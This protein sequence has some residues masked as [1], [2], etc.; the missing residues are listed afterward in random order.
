M[1][2]WETKPLDLRRY[3]EEFGKQYRRYCGAV[4]EG[5]GRKIHQLENLLLRSHSG[6]VLALARPRRRRATRSMAPSSR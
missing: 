6:K 5:H 2:T 3:R 4:H 1:M